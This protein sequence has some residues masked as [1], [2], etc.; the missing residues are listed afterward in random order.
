MQRQKMVS[1]GHLQ[2]TVTMT[3]TCFSHHPTAATLRARYREAARVKFELEHDN[4]NVQLAMMYFRV[5]RFKI[6][7]SKLVTL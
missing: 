1:S 2:P 3:C 6:T 7:L 4:V 5:W